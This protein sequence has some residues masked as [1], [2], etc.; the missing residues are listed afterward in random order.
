MMNWH[1]FNRIQNALIKSILYGVLV[2]SYLLIT[3]CAP[4]EPSFFR[5]DEKWV[6]VLAD[7]Y[8]YQI[9]VESAEKL[10]RDSLESLY[11]TQIIEIHQLDEAELDDFLMALGQNP[12]KA[13]DLYEKVV[14]YLDEI[15]GEIEVQ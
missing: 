5:N 11:K 7:M 3:S 6:P 15:E 4:K 2:L 8:A 13:A 9:A 1:S 12:D 14:S 10:I